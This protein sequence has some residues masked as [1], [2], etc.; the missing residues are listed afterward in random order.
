M[1]RVVR[2][3]NHK[4]QFHAVH[5]FLQLFSLFFHHI[6][7]R[8][9]NERTLEKFIFIENDAAAEGVLWQR[10]HYNMDYI[11]DYNMVTHSKYPHGTINK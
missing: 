2:R 3:S 5:C 1:P 8:K 4:N 7:F 9:K 6:I 11:M 10:L